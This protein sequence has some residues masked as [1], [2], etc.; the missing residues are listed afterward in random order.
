VVLLHGGLANSDYWGL[1]VAALAKD[2]K[3]IV[4][5]SRGMGAVRATNGLTATT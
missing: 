3:V 4:V 5:D 2:H 1:Q